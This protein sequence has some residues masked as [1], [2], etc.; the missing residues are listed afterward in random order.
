VYVI[1]CGEDVTVVSSFKLSADR[2]YAG[3]IVVRLLM[4][5]VVVA[6]LLVIQSVCEYCVDRC[7]GLD[8]S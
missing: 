8:R 1:C 2:F 7:C 6:C 5:N 3:L 4:C